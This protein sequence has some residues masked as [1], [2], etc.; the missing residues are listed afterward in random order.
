MK[1]TGINNSH[2]Q[3]FAENKLGNYIHKSWYIE[4]NLTKHTKANITPH[5]QHPSR[6]E[7]TETINKI[8]LKDINNPKYDISVHGSNDGGY[9]IYLHKVNN[10]NNVTERINNKQNKNN[11]EALLTY[12]LD[13]N[14]KS[15]IHN[16]RLVAELTSEA[17]SYKNN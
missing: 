5:L 14:K 3:H 10:P 13:D 9:T 7:L 16:T 2:S 4:K 17:K 15:V 6:L 11:G 8:N 12:Y 1:I